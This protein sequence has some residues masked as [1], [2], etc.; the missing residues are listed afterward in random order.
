MKYVTCQVVISS[1]AEKQNRQGIEN[2]GV[3]VER[4]GASLTR[5][6]KGISGETAETS[7]WLDLCRAHSVPC[8]KV[9]LSTYYVDV[10]P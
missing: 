10:A 7:V 6:L 9:T 4:V 1:N 8:R 3:F 2:S 5:V